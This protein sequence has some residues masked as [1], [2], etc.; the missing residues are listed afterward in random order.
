MIVVCGKLPGF[1]A[2]SRRHVIL[3]IS[4]LF[5]ERAEWLF[6]ERIPQNAFKLYHP[7]RSYECVAKFGA[8]MSWNPPK[9]LGECVLEKQL[10]GCGHAMQVRCSEDGKRYVLKQGVGGKCPRTPLLS[11]CASH[12]TAEF[13]A[14]SMYGIWGAT[15]PQAAL[16]RIRVQDEDMDVITYVMLTEYKEGEALGIPDTRALEDLQNWAW[17]DLATANFD[18]CGIGL[19]NLKQISSGSDVS[20][21]RLDFG[22]NVAF[23]AAGKPQ[24]NNCKF[25]MKDLDDFRR[26]DSSKSN[27]CVSKSPVNLVLKN[28]MSSGSA[29]QEY[30]VPGLTNGILRK[31]MPKITSRLPGMRKKINEWIWNQ[32]GHALWNDM[33]DIIFMRIVAIE[34]AVKE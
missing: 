10:G 34:A 22:C 15:V 6:E 21:I 17:L 1:L 11:A 29:R 14:L 28:K 18:V 32:Q 12:V 25:S 7:K 8:K 33:V 2:C 13:F 30:I 23:T 31:K 4:Q 26:L 3:S 24:N 5:E 9:S 19:S 27:A 20:V 16:Y